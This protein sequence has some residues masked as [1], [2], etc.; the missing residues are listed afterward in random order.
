[1]METFLL[2]RMYFDMITCNNNLLLKLRGQVDLK[3]TRILSLSQTKSKSAVL[4]KTTNTG[5]KKIQKGEDD[6]IM[7]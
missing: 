4:V 3:T 1:M 5:L 6:V 7:S 2:F